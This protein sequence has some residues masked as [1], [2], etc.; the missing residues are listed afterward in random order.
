MDDALAV[1]NLV[2]FGTVMIG[3]VLVAFLAVATTITLIIC[4]AGQGVASLVSAILRAL[5]RQE[6]P[7]A[8]AE[9]ARTENTR[10]EYTRQA[11]VAKADAILAAR[12]AAA[13]AKSDTPKTEPATPAAMKP[14]GGRGR[15][16]C[17]CKARRR[18]RRTHPAGTCRPP[19]RP[20]HRHPAGSRRRPR[21]LTPSRIP[22]RNHSQ[23]EGPEALSLGAF[24]LAPARYRCAA[25]AGVAPSGPGRLVFRTRRRRAFPAGGPL[26]YLPL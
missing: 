5:R 20:A 19:A 26:G 3:G 10:T 6:Q 18:R 1:T 9:A 22:A 17:P 21:E 8:P 7:A 11:I 2:Y 15:R 23:R 25:G 24:S 16:A 4:G 14:A 13:D 12:R